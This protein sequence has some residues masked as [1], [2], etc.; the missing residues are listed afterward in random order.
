[1][2]K[3][4]HPASLIRLAALIC[5]LKVLTPTPTTNSL[6]AGTPA[7]ILQMARLELVNTEVAGTDAVA[8]AIFDSGSQLR[9]RLNLSI[10]IKTFGSTDSCDQTYDSSWS[11]VKNGVTLTLPWL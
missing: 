2:P 6:C 3:R 7:Q 4:L 1:M 11:E 10:R 8:R 9:E 5:N